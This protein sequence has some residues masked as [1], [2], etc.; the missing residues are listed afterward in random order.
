MAAFS[1]PIGNEP[2]PPSA[3]TVL[4]ASGIA[5]LLK[6]YPNR[7]FVDTLTSIA[8]S[9]ARVGFQGDPVA[10]TQ[11]PNHSSAFDHPEII[12]ESI[13]A[14]LQK[15]RIRQ[16]PDLPPNYFCSPIGLTP[17]Y[18]DGVQTG[19]RVIFDLSAPRGK[20]VNDGIP[21]E[22]GTLVYETL[23]DAIQLVAQAGKGAVMMK[24][25]LKAAFRHIPINP[26][27]Y[28]LL[29]F[30]WNGQFFVDMF[31]PFGLRTA[32]RIF[33][34]F[35]EALHWIF[36]TLYEWNVTHYL[37]DFLFVFPPHTEISSI[38]AQFDDVLAEFGL[39]KAKEKD[40]NG[41]VV[42][43]LGFEFDSE[44]MQV[45][46]PP[47]KKQRALDAIRA[48]LLPSTVTL[49]ALETTLGFLSH[50]CQVVP[51]G[52]PFLRNLFS[53]ICRSSS[54]RHPHRI[55][56]SHASRQDL[57]WWLQFLR[58][59]SSISMIH[60][61]RISF[62][63]ATD[64]SGKKGIGGVH[65]RIVFSE[66]IPSRH[67]SKKINWKEMFAILHAFMLWHEMWRGGLVRIAC[68]NSSV[69]DA[70]NKHSIKG[71]SIVPLQRIFLI[72]AVYD[73][74]IF[75]FWIPSEE[76]MVADAA[77]RFDYKKLA[78]LGLQVSR[79]LPRPVLLR[80]KLHSFFTTPSLQAQGGTT[81]K[82]S[83]PMCL[84]A[85]GIITS[86]T[87]PPSKRYHT[88]LLNSSHPSNPLPQNL[89][90]GHSN[91]STFELVNQPLHLRTNASISSSGVE[92]GYM[93]KEL[94]RSDTPLRQTSSNK[95][96]TKSLMTKRESMSRPPSV[97]ALPPSY[98]LENLRGIRG[99]QTPTDSTSL[100]NM[101]SSNPM[102]Q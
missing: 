83:K 63:V 84:S 57:R 29:L 94:R 72:A 87:H 46:L 66:R 19:W 75:P 82:S 74:Q 17:K 76:N 31:L 49:S 18:T 24:R 77:S 15:G 23:N 54:R 96:S 97:W 16:I 47:N 60:L 36:E 102:D 90:S 8:I 42:V 7:R 50:C 35:A 32:P 10:R 61:S 6:T 86:P 99:P 1:L 58:S 14:E 100:V 70:L 62:D 85:R 26:C 65:R 52:R 22:Y 41:C 5:Q 9:G 44:L 28:W 25:D 33:N 69:V 34:L 51:L 81:R 45:R 38:S 79:H 71:P 40:L 101:S 56:L 67:K 2:L 4:R 43:H 59:W 13:Q 78:N 53:Q 88:G 73:I 37:D 92:N 12:G 21:R 64:A 3:A 98:D 91:P 30:E 89:I 27:D 68:D 55:Q 80:R 11:R 93:A 48:L 95:W 39:T 20:S